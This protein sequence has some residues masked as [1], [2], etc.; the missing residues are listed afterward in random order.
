MGG[1]GSSF[2]EG[3]VQRGPE[4]H[5]FASVYQEPRS[6]LEYDQ[7]FN[8]VRK[9]PYHFD[10]WGLTRSVDGASFLA[11]NG[12][13]SVMTLASDGSFNLKEAKQATCLGK[14]VPALNEL[15][16]VPDFLGQGPAL[17]GN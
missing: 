14:P 11:T 7:N 4:G 2:I 12:S 10:G 3:I 8:Y 13:S 17:L 9:H 15:E 1:I 5:W 6:T 16:M